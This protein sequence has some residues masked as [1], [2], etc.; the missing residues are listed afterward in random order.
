MSDKVSDAVRAEISARLSPGE[1]SDE[2]LVPA[3][4]RF[5]DTSR[6]VRFDECD[7]DGRMR[8]AGVLRHAQDLA[9][10]HSDELEFSREWYTARGVG[11][12]VRAIDLLVDDLPGPSTPLIGTTA[13]VGFRHVMARRRTRLFVADGRVLADAAIDWVMVDGDGRPVRF[14]KEFE[15]FVAEVGESFTPTKIPALDASTSSKSIEIPL[16]VADIDPLGH[17]NNAAW[18]ELV[19]EALSSAAPELLA[20]P[21]RRFR[22]EYLGITAATS[23]ILKVQRHDGGARIDAVDPIGTQLLRGIVESV[24]HS[25]HSG[26]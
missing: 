17:V 6:H 26:R 18:L 13:L 5:R 1:A 24:P 14:P 4:A 21:R 2:R 10:L 7:R 25:R 16:R 11:W 8:A 12:V 19:E 9:W 20:A 23:V 3:R 22:L 15:A